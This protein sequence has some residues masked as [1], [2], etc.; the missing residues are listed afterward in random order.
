MGVRR[1]TNGGR[2]NIGKF[3]S[4]KN[5]RAIWYESLLERDY[6][7][8]LEID[9]DV[10]S[11]DSQPFR[12][13]YFIDKEPHHYTPDIRVVKKNITEIVEVKP[14]RKTLEA[15]F[16]SLVKR[17]APICAREG[18]KYRVATEATIR[19]EPRL[20]NIKVLFKYCR[21]DITFQDQA[22]LYR[23]FST[24]KEATVKEIQEF[25]LPSD[26]AKQI[27]YALIFWG[28][29]STDLNKVINPG[30]LVHL[31]ALDLGR[32]STYEEQL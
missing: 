12:I 4:L 28:L 29:I 8:L 7:Y 15:E 16:I 14:E 31:S 1:P 13:R 22:D 10:I 18:F 26:Q 27:T 19:M 20:S 11:F 3:P 23:F 24:R 25:L 30:S 17:I 2:K 5:R 6:M 21:T 32:I 9:P